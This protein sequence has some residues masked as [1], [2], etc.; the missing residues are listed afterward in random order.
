MKKIWKCGTVVFVFQMLA[1]AIVY[2][3]TNNLSL[4]A[5]TVIG[6]AFA[7]L[8][9]T[10]AI[11]I[12]TATAFVTVAFTSVLAAAAIIMLV[13]TPIGADVIF[14]AAFVFFLAGIA[15]LIRGE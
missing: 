11:S 14:A 15:A 2:G 4:T 8:F 12:S 7:A 10:S 6:V 1:A 3:E 13:G 9:F 5:L